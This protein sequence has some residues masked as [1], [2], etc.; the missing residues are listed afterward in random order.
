MEDLKLEK[1]SCPNCQS[2]DFKIIDNIVC[3]NYCLSKFT[4]KQINS[5]MFVDLR[6]AN[7]ERNQANFDKAKT[8]YLNIIK[9]NANEDLTDVYWGLFLCEQRVLFEED[10]KGEKFP[11]FYRLNQDNSIEDSSYFGKVLSYALKHNKEKL[12]VFNNL[13]EKIENARKIYLDIKN[14]TKPFDI[15]ICFKNTDNNGNY[16]NDR[17]LAMDIYNEFSDKYNI[18]FSEKTLKNIKSNYREY[19]PNI[20]YGLYTAKVML[21]LCS[22]TEYLESKWLKNEWNRFSSINKQGTD[23]KCIIPIFTDN[24][25]PNDLPESLWHN[26]GIFDDRKLISTLQTQLENIIHPVDK[27]EALRKE[28]EEQ[29]KEQEERLK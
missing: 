21:L 9:N 5:Q 1:F 3:C 26:Q 12:E 4:K 22:K 15:F 13:A 8:I 14:T 28:Q 7:I 17:Q 24:F 27:L 23:N 10:G 11:S 16:T 18:F 19:E 25:N 20:Y 2:N 6:L 29:R